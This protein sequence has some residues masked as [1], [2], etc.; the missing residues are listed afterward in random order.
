[1]GW[2]NMLS[3]WQWLIMAAVPPLI[4]MLY[5]LKLRRQ[6]IAVPS[7][8]LWRKT[9]EDLHVN[10]IWQRLRNNLLLWLQLLAVLVLA[11]ACLSPGF[12][13]ESSL[14]ERSIFLIDNSCS[15][16]ASD[17]DVDRLSAAKERAFE[18][19]D[20]MARSDVAMVIAF[21]DRAD[22]RQG[23]TSDK[24]KLKSA[25]ESIEP[26]N[27]TTDLNEAL[28]AASGLANPGRTSQIEDMNDIQVAEAVPAKLF[29]LSD[30]GFPA[31][32][33]D[34]GNLTAEYIPIGGESSSNVAIVAFTVERNLEGGGEIE[35][36]ARVQNFG[37]QEITTNA[38]LRLGEELLDAV[39]VTVPAN[40]STGV[41]FQLKS[42]EEGQLQLMLDI[43]DDLKADNTA[44]AGLDPPRQLEVVL[45]TGGNTPLEAALATQA[46]DRLALVRKLDPQ[47]L[48]TD[49]YKQLALS[50]TVDLF[51]FDVCSPE[52]MPSSNTLFLGGIPPGD[53]WQAGEQAGPLFIIDSN[54]AHPILQYVDMGTVRIVEGQALGV[55]EA[56]TELLRTD[57]GVLMAVAPRGPYQD[58]VLAMSFM[59]AAEGGV[60]PNTDWPIKRSFPVFVLNCLEYLGGS[61]ST[62]GSR[63]F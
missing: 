11:L 8:Y 21:N 7:T 12:R 2:V 53:E 28:R 42:I 54:R 59:R 37:D 22:V 24:R 62:A 17:M 16:Q 1:M 57:A 47:A 25:V 36:F 55:P 20:S 38:E 4:L 39:E 19:I 35:A 27:R 9:V 31:P 49:E 34:L 56:A 15:M 18:M 33:L 46:A 51:I 10:S 60:V 6:P 32:Q 61:V 14:G 58:A 40:E 45:V 23:F 29:I 13:G 44:Y 30:G 5:F 3:W 43:D 50:G 26:T 52:V 63:T 48:A 41:S